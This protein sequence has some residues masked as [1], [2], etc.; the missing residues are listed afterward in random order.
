MENKLYPKVLVVGQTFHRN[1]GGGVTISNLFKNWP[2]NKLFSINRGGTDLDY[3]S[4]RN[5]Y[6]MNT[7]EQY[8]FLCRF[9]FSRKKF[10]KP[11]NG[12]KKNISKAF[13]TYSLK[14]IVKNLLLSIIVFIGLTRY[15]RTARVSKRLKIWLDLQNVDI[16]YAQFS[17]YPSMKFALNIHSYLSIPLFIHIM[18]DWIILPTTNPKASLFMENGISRRYWKNRELLIFNKLVDKASV[19][20]AIS[21]AMAQEYTKR[22]NKQFLWAHNFITEAKILDAAPKTFIPKKD[23]TIGYYGTINSKNKNNF[24]DL[25]SA[26]ENID[27]FNII[28]NIYT[29]DTN[30]F[31]LEN[32]PKVNIKKMLTTHKY[33]HSLSESTLLFMPLDFNRNSIK[34][35]K[36]SFPTKM[37][38]YLISGTPI[39]VYCP[40][41]T[42]LAKFCINTSNSILVTVQSVSVLKK[43]LLKSLKYEN[44][45]L[46]V[47]KKGIC[48]ARDYLSESVIL[49]KFENQFFI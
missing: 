18:D 21:N 31:G 4:C 13:G 11:D 44:H 22:Y 7:N 17:D 45:Y 2:K 26:I 14:A 24:L 49:P 28:L 3:S 9:F 27:E 16:I 29:S 46:Q 15:F 40:P 35:T 48:V 5:I 37:S 10:K 6:L 39:V 32:R 20:F 1:N 30:L 36:L 8:S 38:E 19:C 12:I 42:A 23:I 47:S 43:A 34:Y 41:E 25:A 33:W